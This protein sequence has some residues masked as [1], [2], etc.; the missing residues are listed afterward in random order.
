VKGYHISA[1]DGE[2]GHV[3]DFIFDD[4]DWA[5]RFI[6]IKTGGW[7][8]GRKTLIAPKSIE[9]ISW[10]ESKMFVGLTR[11]QIASSPEYLEE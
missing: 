3:N 7:L 5:I 9:G 4:E 1:V 2:I 6:V 10:T 11:D 8:L